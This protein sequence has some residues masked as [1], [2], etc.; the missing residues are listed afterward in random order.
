[1]PSI[2]SYSTP[3]TSLLKDTHKTINAT[4]VNSSNEIE[5]SNFHSFEQTNMTTNPS[6]T[7]LIRDEIQS[8]NDD[9]STNLRTKPSV[10]ASVSPFPCPDLQQERCFEE[11][12]TSMNRAIDKQPSV[13][14]ATNI[15][16]TTNIQPA[17]ENASS[18]GGASASVKQSPT[19]RAVGL[20]TSAQ[21]HVPIMTSSCSTIFMEQS[22]LSSHGKK[23]KKRKRNANDT[24]VMIDGIPEDTTSN[25]TPN[26][27]SLRASRYGTTGRWTAQ[28]HQAFVRGLALYGREWKRVALDIPTRTSAQVRSHAQKYLSKMEK[29][30]SLGH[31]DNETD[32]RFLDHSTKNSGT[33]VISQSNNFQSYNDLTIAT[34][35]SPTASLLATNIQVSA[36]S[37]TL[38]EDGSPTGSHQHDTETDYETMSDSV[39]QQ[40]ARIL[41]NPT[42]VEQEVRD[43]ISQL[44]VRYHQLQEKIQQQQQQQLQQQQQQQ[45][46]HQVRTSTFDNRNI[47][48][49]RPMH[50][51]ETNI[52]SNNFNVSGI[53]QRNTNNHTS[54]TTTTS[55]GTQQGVLYVHHD[56]DELIALHVLQG[57]QKQQLRI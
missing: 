35:Q 16:T 12:E 13:V 5:G 14:Q 44:R 23:S 36:T 29:Q 24:S 32:H 31:V 3:S 51:G 33:P 7:S 43:T 18:M 27:M 17:T 8:H 2:H 37:H 39:R 19:E 28:E 41:A 4:N 54:S 38:E 9:S 11:Q 48:V 42:T 45:Q 55:T 6:N 10:F 34:E 40:A 46:H 30:L 52:G 56:D 25:S 20:S 50:Q 21:F 1:M 22:M 47:V 26:A 53:G 57:L 49:Q 15:N